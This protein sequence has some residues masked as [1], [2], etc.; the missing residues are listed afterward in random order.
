[1]FLMELKRTNLP[2]MWAW[3]IST[4]AKLPGVT[5]KIKN[6]FRCFKDKDDDANDDGMEQK[7]TKVLSKMMVIT[8]MMRAMEMIESK[9]S[10]K[11][12]VAA[13]CCQ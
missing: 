10:F 4:W 1:M 2:A 13:P 3:T 6:M 9:S 8:P 5:F 11:Y 12:D 7:K